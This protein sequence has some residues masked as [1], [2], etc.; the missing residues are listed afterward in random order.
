MA[1]NKKRSSGSKRKS[2]KDKYGGF[3]IFVGMMTAGLIGII[4]AIG[5]YIFIIV[6]GQSFLMDNIDKL[7]LNEAT[8]LYDSDG[9]RLMRLY[10]ENRENVTLDEVPEKLQ[11]AFIATEDKR[12]SSHIGIDIQSIGRALYKDIIHMS[13]VEGGSTITQQLA[14]NI[15]LNSH[16]TMFRKVQEASIAIALEN[17]F[18]KGQILE[19]YLNRIYFGKGAYG[20]KA[21]AMLYFGKDDLNDLTL[22]Q[23][24]T[25]AGIPKAPSH[26]SP[27]ENVEKSKERR[28][29]VLALMADQGYISEQEK[30]EAQAESLEVT[31]YVIGSRKDYTTFVD[32]VIKEAVEQYGI[33]EDELLRGGYHIYTTVNLAAQK[34]LD[35]AFANDKLFQEDMNG[36]KMQ[37]SM[38]IYDHKNGAILALAGGRDY[39][40]KGWNRAVKPRQP[41]SA[42][43]PI[44]SYAPALES[45]KWNP[46]S[47]LKDE[48]MSFGKYSPRNYDNKY[49][50]Q[51]TM[52]E[53]VRK[54]ANIPAVWM[55]DQV[56]I[57]QS[58]KLATKLGIEFAPED[59]NLAIALGG[60][61]HGV[62][63]MQMVRAYGAFANE[64]KMFVPHSIVKIVDTNDKTV[65]EAK[66]EA[67]QVLS[68]QT[69]YSMTKMLQTVVESGT[70]TAAKMDRPIAGKTGSTQ[71]DIKG[72][73]RYNR[74]LWFV[75]YTP[76]WTAAVWM[77]FDNTNK[78]HYVTISSGSPAALFKHV[79]SK[80]LAGQPV[81]QFVKPQGVVDP[82]ERPKTVQHLE[83]LLENDGQSVLL[84][85]SAVDGD[86]SYLLYRKEVEE[87]EYTEFPPVTQT[88]LKD[89][90]VQSGK[91]YEYYVVVKNRT[92]GMMSDQSNVVKIELTAE[93]DLPD[94]LDPSDDL[95]PLEPLDP[96]FPLD[97]LLPGGG[98][99]DP[100]EPTDPADPTDPSDPFD[101]DDGQDNNVEDEDLSDDER[102]IL[103]RLRN[104]N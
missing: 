18:S 32:F 86:V 77:G 92:T 55:L 59:R 15:F 61:T 94:P 26:Y 66:S 27:M 20:V 75:G 103:D 104:R 23:M 84:R 78:D 102:S 46:Y 97:P 5:L 25:L 83:A 22:A 60:M 90:T 14:K 2:K 80:A 33:S 88:E 7:D 8:T 73:E 6:S 3:R 24:A 43:K 93:T 44:I 42:F 28:N 9:N 1:N 85:W 41:G 38:V 62:T 65:G 72:L 54:S 82:T 63:P 99:L 96:S 70:G 40:A 29:L 11:A 35:E 100:L 64:G 21:A 79:M 91:T 39:V 36:E 51:I 31:P 48:Q 81:S 17:N 47:L 34:A 95:E 53:A 101:Q 74:D 4:G 49:L 52:M 71:L 13:A 19:K 16:K 98:I 69:A 10:V 68:A 76:E 58:M 67:V 45:G 37:G 12:F 89:R 87:T 57:D 30:L 56:G 50:G